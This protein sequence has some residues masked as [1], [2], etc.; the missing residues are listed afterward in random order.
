MC[1]IESLVGRTL[2]PLDSPDTLQQAVCW[3]EPGLMTKA[4]ICF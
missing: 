2:A 4:G 1:K 3:G